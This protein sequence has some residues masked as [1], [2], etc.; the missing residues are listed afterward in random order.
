MD[1]LMIFMKYI[2]RFFVITFMMI[3]CAI[4]NLNAA[5]KDHSQ[6]GN[7][8]ILENKTKNF[9]LE[10]PDSFDP[11]D[12]WLCHPSCKCVYSNPLDSE[13]SKTITFGS[14]YH[15]GK[16][17]DGF[18][19]IAHL[20]NL[21]PENQ[22]D[23]EYEFKVTMNEKS[24]SFPQLGAILPCTNVRKACFLKPDHSC[25]IGVMYSVEWKVDGWKITFEEEEF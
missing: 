23:E 9:I 12:C 13:Q 1:N 14:G 7:V 10:F 2:F 6:G 21:D 25:H 5:K 4:V 8:L 16:E 20:K 24:R 3:L 15:Y 19:V 17:D 22:E 11:Y 18:R